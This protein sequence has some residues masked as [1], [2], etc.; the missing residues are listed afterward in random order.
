MKR[1]FAFLL[2]C[3]GLE[4]TGVALVLAG[5]EPAWLA[6][7][8]VACLCGL[9]GGIGGAVYCLRALYLNACAGDGWTPKWMPWYFIRPVVSLVCGIV[10][11]L[12][13]QAGLLVLE[14]TPRAESNHLGFYVLAFVAGL[15]V[16]K[17]LTKIEEVAQTT[18]GIE[19]TRTARRDDLAAAR[20][21]QP[22]PD[23]P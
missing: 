1:A 6:S 16:D 20:A 14:S 4:A 12:L 18:W 3:L 10:S 2:I 23:S 7:A 17:F 11:Y 5:A 13:L 19:R 21:V 22:P 15:N 9:T 8:N